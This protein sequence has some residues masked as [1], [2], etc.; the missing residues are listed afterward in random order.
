MTL[1]IS[2]KKGNLITERLL[3]FFLKKSLGNE[4]I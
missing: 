2:S 3:D 4:F 1:V